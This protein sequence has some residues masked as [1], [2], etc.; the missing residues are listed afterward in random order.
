MQLSDIRFLVEFY[1][2]FSLTTFIC[3]LC[4]LGTQKE[5]F[6]ISLRVNDNVILLYICANQKPPL[7]VMSEGGSPCKGKVS[8]GNVGV[9]L[10][11]LRSCTC[12]SHAVSV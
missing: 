9:V 11:L 10:R 5:S 2:M 3:V 12:L 6:K 7:M 1:C 8:C 4:S